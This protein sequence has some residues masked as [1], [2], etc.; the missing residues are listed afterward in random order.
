MFIH[1]RSFATCMFTILGTSSALTYALPRWLGRSFTVRS[2]SLWEWL[3]YKQRIKDDNDKGIDSPLRIYSGLGVTSIFTDCQSTH[4]HFGSV[5]HAILFGR[6][7]DG[8]ES[9]E[10]DRGVVC[11]GARWFVVLA[12]Q[13]RNPTMVTL[14]YPYCA[15][16]GMNFNEGIAKSI[17]VLVILVT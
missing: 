2:I 7:D 10:E 5:V 1:F 3:G 13:L 11:I 8:Q 4:P 6:I 9:A 16:P 15:G 12:F 14:L 17:D